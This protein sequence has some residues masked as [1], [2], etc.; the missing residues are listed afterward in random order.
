[1]RLT[2][3]VKLE[4]WHSCYGCPMCD[5]EVEPLRIYECLGEKVRWY[6]CKKGFKPKLVLKSKNPKR[7]NCIIR[8]KKCIEK[9]GK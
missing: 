3:T 8:P 4:D 6:G 7:V 1:M 5:Y 2:I 9:F